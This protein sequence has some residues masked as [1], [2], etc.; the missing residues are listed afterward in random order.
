MK[1]KSKYASFIYL[2]KMKCVNS[3]Q[4]LNNTK[5]SMNNI[6]YMYEHSISIKHY[7]LLAIDI[8]LRRCPEN[9]IRQNLQE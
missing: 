7:T 4:M 1:S 8:K 2:K 3:D 6:N 9:E 5:I